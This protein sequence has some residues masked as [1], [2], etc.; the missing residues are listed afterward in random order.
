MD[1]G[2]EIEEVYGVIRNFRHPYIE[3]EDFGGAII[4]FRGGKVGIVEGT[5]DIYPRNLHEKLGIFGERGDVM[6]GGLAVNRIEE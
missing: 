4:K 3:A 5:T 2:G 6:I 1:A